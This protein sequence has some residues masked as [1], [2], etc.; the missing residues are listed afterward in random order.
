MYNQDPP[1]E[2]LHLVQPST[3]PTPE[4]KWFPP[5]PS[6]EQPTPRPIKVKRTLHW[7]QWVT[8]TIVIFTCLMVLMALYD[9]YNFINHLQHALQQFSDG[10]SKDF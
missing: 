10:L 6:L 8:Y 4:A 2:K 9:A 1:T 5:D 3:Y 7:Y